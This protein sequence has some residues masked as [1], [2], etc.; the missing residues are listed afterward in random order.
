MKKPKHQ[1][2]AFLQ[3]FTS[4]DVL[5]ALN[6]YKKGME[7]SF[8][9]T[10]ESL[11]EDGWYP[12]SEKPKDREFFE[13]NDQY[14]IQTEEARLRDIEKAKQAM[15]DNPKRKKSRRK[16]LD[17]ELN[18]IDSFKCP[19]CGSGLYRQKVCPGC[20]EGKQGFSV[21]LICEE[22]AEHEFLI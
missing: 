14:W 8:N 16:K 22:N 2:L 11:K 15:R 12:V 20:T 1:I 21:R 9:S 3:G 17:M 5:A 6:T 18:Y 4:E 10:E 13:L 19:Q 7:E